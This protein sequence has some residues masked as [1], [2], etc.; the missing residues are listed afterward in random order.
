M[1][2]I[3]LEQKSYQPGEVCKGTVVWTEELG[4][5][6]KSVKVSLCY[7]TSG[8]GTQDKATSKELMLNSSK[9]RGEFSFV[10]PE[11]PITFAGKFI[12]VEWYIE[13]KQP[14]SWKSV[15]QVIQLSSTGEV[16]TLPRASPVTPPQKDW[17]TR[18][19]GGIPFKR[20]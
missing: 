8:R 15:E 10:L 16:V 18:Y 1:I 3:Q 9:E 11:S 5:K 17:F 14:M 20:S 6:G 4:S 19:F 7:R 2:K 12:S 13:A